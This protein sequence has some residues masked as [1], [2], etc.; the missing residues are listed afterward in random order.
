[1]VDDVHQG[2][3]TE[4]NS[5]L[6]VEEFLGGD[7]LKEVCDGEFIIHTVCKFL[8]YIPDVGFPAGMDRTSDLFGKIFCRNFR[9]IRYVAVKLILGTELSDFI[10]DSATA[11]SSVDGN[12]LDYDVLMVRIRA[13]DYLPKNNEQDLRPPVQEKR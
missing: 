2:F 9:Y 13:D 5:L 6:R 10:R 8:D 3:L 1:M 11:A 12:C 7:Y 4:G